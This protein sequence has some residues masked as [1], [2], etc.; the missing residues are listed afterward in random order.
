LCLLGHFAAR[1]VNKIYLPLF[2]NEDAIFSHLSMENKRESAL[3][4]IEL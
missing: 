2:G 1:Q 3:G 4:L